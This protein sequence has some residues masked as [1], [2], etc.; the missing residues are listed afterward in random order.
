MMR[1]NWKVIPHIVSIVCTAESNGLRGCGKFAGIQSIVSQ[2]GTTSE[3]HPLVSRT[4]LCA[5]PGGEEVL[6]F[7][8]R[9]EKPLAIPRPPRDPSLTAPEAVR[10]DVCGVRWCVGRVPMGGLG[11][12]GHVSVHREGFRVVWCQLAARLGEAETK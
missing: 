5:A 8:N 6:A 1:K 4:H 12:G 10:R 9:R 3:F 11:A 2:F 7:I